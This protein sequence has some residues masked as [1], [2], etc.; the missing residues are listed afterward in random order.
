LNNLANSIRDRLADRQLVNLIPNR[1]RQLIQ[2]MVD[3]NIG[4]LNRTKKQPVSR[5]ELEDRLRQLQNNADAIVNRAQNVQQ[6]QEYI[7]ATK[8]KKN[9][10]EVGKHLNNDDKRKVD[11]ALNDAQDWLSLNRNSPNVSADQ[12]EERLSNLRDQ[13]KPVIDKAQEKKDLVEYAQELQK[14]LTDDK[15]L[16][17]NLTPDEKRKLTDKV[18]DELRW[19]NSSP[20]A[21]MDEIRDH[22]NKLENVVQPVIDR[23]DA[24]IA[25]SEFIKSTKDQLNNDKELAANM[26]DDERRVVDNTVRDAENWLDKNG[27]KA[28]KRDFD[29]KK[30]EVQNKVN[31]LV[32]KAKEKKN[33]VQYASNIRD[34]IKNDAQLAAILS[35]DDKRL[36]DEAAA[37]VIN[38]VKKHGDK[39]SLAELKKKK[40]ELEK[41]INS[42]LESKDERNNLSD[43]AK[44]VLDILKSNEE[45]RKG[46]TNDE[47]RDVDDYAQAVLD[48]LA[49][50]PNATAQEIRNMKKQLEDN[51]AKV[52]NFKFVVP[53]KNF[54]G[55]RF[56]EQSRWG[57]SE[58]RS[59]E[60][61]YGS[62]LQQQ[63]RREREAAAKRQ[64]NQKPK[65]ESKP[66][67][68]GEKKFK[69][70]AK[71]K[72]SVTKQDEEDLKL[73]Q[74]LK[75]SK[76]GLI[77]AKL[78]SLVDTTGSVKAEFGSV[79]DQGSSKSLPTY[80]YAELKNGNNGF[81]K[82]VDPQRREQYLST[83]EFQQIF[84]MTKDEFNRLPN[85]R[86]HG[87]KKTYE[88]F[89]FEYEK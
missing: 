10:P 85:F 35:K 58:N 70:A 30:K 67:P 12:V 84:K 63:E 4:F 62:Y 42:I 1:D 66:A 18:N 50:H 49:E 57:I 44:K 64:Q 69:V 34:R 56:N 77:Q 29:H 21:T 11:A 9:D 36:I 38:W 89:Q 48:W 60:F 33:L 53:Y 39:A 26:T 7:E 83:G 52:K 80:S 88:L 14:R 31:P 24:K 13:V 82:G 75:G 78:S 19:V 81:P 37:E 16:L 8:N 23:A 47:Q 43:Y 25:L 45:V 27:A 61:I 28:T 15:T 59:K 87:L 73:F 40:D 22:R 65:E 2:N 76:G 5:Q 68:T 3:E 55:F 32:D 71:S 17:A 74:T 41:T 46:M 51:L 6:L 86:Q 54:V 72:Y 79:V 20:N